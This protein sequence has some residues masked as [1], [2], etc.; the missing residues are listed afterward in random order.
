VHLVPSWRTGAGQIKTTGVV[1][2]DRRGLRQEGMKFPIVTENYPTQ[3]GHLADP[4]V[5]GRRLAEL[6]LVFAIVVIFN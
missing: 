4:F 2:F 6:E 5:V 3:R 1:L